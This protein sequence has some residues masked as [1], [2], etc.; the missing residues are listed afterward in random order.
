[1]VNYPRAKIINQLRP[2]IR[3]NLKFPKVVLFLRR[4]LAS[5]KKEDV[6]DGARIDDLMFRTMPL[7][8]FNMSPYVWSIGTC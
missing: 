1:M 4:K 8:D 3:P 5:E 7:S 2:S 6:D